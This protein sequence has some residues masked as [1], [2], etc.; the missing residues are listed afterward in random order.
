M[1]KVIC[2][3]ALCA[4]LFAQEIPKVVEIRNLDVNMLG[5]FLGAFGVNYSYVGGSRFIALRGTREAVIA[6]EEAL[7]RMDVPRK[8][9]ELSFQIV[10]ASTQPGNEKVPADLDPVIKQLKST[11]VYQSYRLLD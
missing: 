4:S 9:M 1:K 5:G 11:F 3:L 8:N 10:A 2:L 7:K 6:A